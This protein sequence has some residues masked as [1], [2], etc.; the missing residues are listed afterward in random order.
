MQS[1][2]VLCWKEE[3][4]NSGRAELTQTPLHWLVACAASAIFQQLKLNQENK[5][6]RVFFYVCNICSLTFDSVDFFF[7]QDA[8]IS[9]NV[10]KQFCND[11]QY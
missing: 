8:V 1:L 9:Q 3:K 7:Y 11:C 6:D 5:L 2:F 10:L 4:A